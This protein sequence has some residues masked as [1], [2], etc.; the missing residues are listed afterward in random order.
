[1]STKISRAELERTLQIIRQAKQ[2]DAEAQFTLG[3]LSQEGKIIPQDNEQAEKWFRH[4]AEQGHSQAEQKLT[5]LKEANPIDT[6]VSLAIDTAV[7]QIALQGNTQAQYQL[8]MKYL[9]GQDLPQDFKQ[10]IC[11]F[12]KAASRGHKEAQ[13]R[14]GTLYQEGK[15]ASK[16]DTLAAI[17]FR[18]AAEQGHPGAL[19]RFERMGLNT[20]SGRRVFLWVLGISGVAAVILLLTRCRYYGGSSGNNAVYNAGFC[21]GGGG[22]G[23]G[24]GG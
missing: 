23:R 10:A 15:G 21:G 2:G 11:W 20:V 12:F 7:H 17:W 22:V 6:P 13:Y 16:S 4:A 5:A 8:G 18:K 19:N 9:K 1:M 24:R 14:L 3:L